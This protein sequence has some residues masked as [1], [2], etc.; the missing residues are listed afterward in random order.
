MQPLLQGLFAPQL[1]PQ[2]ADPSASLRNCRAETVPAQR[3]PMTRA[4]KNIDLIF[5][6]MAFLRL[7][8]VN[9]ERLF[10]RLGCDE[11]AHAC[12]ESRLNDTPAA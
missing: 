5:F 10:C 4:A 9:D 7:S 12:R 2:V 11:I 1:P 8:V 3:T 6:M